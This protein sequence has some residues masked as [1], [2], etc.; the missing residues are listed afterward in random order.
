MQQLD[1]WFERKPNG[2]YKF[3][4]S[5]PHQ[6]Y[7]QGESWV[8]ELG[9]SAVEFRTTFDRFA[10]RYKSKS[11]FDRAPDKFQG[12]FYCSYHDK[13]A[14]LTWY[15]RNHTMLDQALDDLLMVK[16]PAETP[17][18]GG[19]NSGFPPHF[20]VTPTAAS[21]GY[22]PAA[23]PVTAPAV[24][25]GKAAQALPINEAGEAL[26]TT[27]AQAP[28]NTHDSAPRATLDLVQEPLPAQLMEHRQAQSGITKTTAD[29]QRPLPQ[30]ANEQELEG[31]N[32]GEAGENRG[33]G[34]LDLIFPTK[35]SSQ[36][37]A[38]LTDLLAGCSKT[39]RQAVL[40]ELEGYIRADKITA[41]IIPLARS[42][43][44][45]VGDGKFAPNYG[46]AVL[47]ER[48][49]KQ[50]HLAAIA[51]MAS[52]TSGETSGE[53]NPLGLALLPPAMR[54]RAEASLMK[55]EER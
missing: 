12:K 30:T 51:V 49:T 4:E 47:G 8:E 1:Y 9:I 6:L 18:N 41:G 5:C 37:R 43:V 46:V 15:F 35:A 11:E 45:A 31:V 20:P 3:L 25:T 22:T 36:E 42:L 21:T 19:Q 34:S 32:D 27:A 14:Q 52:S 40:D 33:S 38:V 17:Q 39:C 48:E 28:I 29:F 13:R 50:R 55:R 53:I 2:F 16:I 54:R 24:V 26:R 7:R 44:R 10:T 23:F